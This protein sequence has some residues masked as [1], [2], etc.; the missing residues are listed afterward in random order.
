MASG[1][2]ILL[3]AAAAG[4]SGFKPGRETAVPPVRWPAE[5]LSL[6]EGTVASTLYPFDKYILPNKLTLIVKEVHAT[7]IVAVYFWVGSGSVNE[8]PEISGISHFFEHMFFKGTE[9]RKVGEM[10]MIVKGLG[11][12]S[13]AFTSLD[14]T[15]Y[16]VVLPAQHFTTA[17]DILLD[18]VRHSTFDPAELE[19]ERKVIE[20]EINLKEDNPEDKVVFEFCKTAFA[21][22]PYGEPILGT[23]K[24]LEGI[25]REDF[26][27][28]LRNFYVPNNMIV[29]VVGDVRIAEVKD[30]VEK[31]TADF[32]PDPG[33]E[34]RRKKIAF[35]PQETE[36]EASFDK[37]VKQAYLIAGFTNHG[38]A[39]PSEVCV[40]DVISSILGGGKSSRLYQRLLEKE[41][42]VTEISA[43]IWALKSA[44]VLA[45]TT[46]SAPENA[47]RVK[48]EIFEE[49]ERLRTG[50]VNE[51]ELRR[52]KKNLTSDFAY[53]NETCSSMASTF[54]HYE[55]LTRA[56]DAL[57]YVDRVNAV[58]AEDV[59]R[60]LDEYCRGGR[61][62]VCTVV[63]G[64]KRQ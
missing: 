46:V 40:L 54:G 57:T 43:W 51:E 32:A 29:A 19:R 47:E 35:V 17:F 12:Y 26:F 23:V 56:E 27:T 13:N 10:D 21:G 1:F 39:R 3:L 44:G 31:A 34:E 62:T 36:R 14:Y 16:Y 37:D 18:A 15:G 58:K 50:G 6:R 48:T 42:I 9:K 2:V 5:K 38:M 24:S 53:G 63:P 8:T 55:I 11:G 61:A 25:R 45:V 28:Y 30:F 49:I 22:T 59:R 20:E 7:P 41:G 4:C 60:L 33:L 64:E 52:A